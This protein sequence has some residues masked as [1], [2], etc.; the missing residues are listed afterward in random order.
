MV[1]DVEDPFSK[2]GFDAD[3][4]VSQ[5]LRQCGAEG[6]GAE[7]ERL[8]QVSKRA[9]EEVERIVTKHR[10]ALLDRVRSV[11]VAEREAQ[12]LRRDV[13]SLQR[14][15]QRARAE[16]RAPYE[17]VQTHTAQVKHIGESLEILR[18]VLKRKKINERLRSQLKSTTKKEGEEETVV[19]LPK[20]AR[21]YRELQQAAEEYDLSGIRVVE[22]DESWL[23]EAGSIIKARADA[24]LQQGMEGL[25]LTDVGTALLV[26]SNLGELQEAIEAQMSRYNR[27]VSQ[28]AG[29]WLEPTVNISKGV[30]PGG[31]KRVGGPTPGGTQ[32]WQETFWNQMQEFANTV[33]ECIHAVWF[34]Y[35]VMCRRRDPVTRSLLIEYIP[36][37]NV[38]E[39]VL[40]Q[41][42][43]EKMCA[44]VNGRIEKGM[45]SSNIRDILLANYPKELQILRSSLDKLQ[46]STR[47]KGVA[48]ALQARRIDQILLDMTKTIQTAYITRVL[49]RLNE[50]VR[51]Q[52]PPNLRA[53][54]PIG[55]PDQFV[56]RIIHE[57]QVA[58]TNTVL[59]DMV[60]SAA[61][62]T[63]HLLLERAEM[64]IDTSDELVLIEDA[65]NHAQ[66]RNIDICNFLQGV[67]VEVGR[68]VEALPV[69]PADRLQ[70]PLRGIKGIAENSVARMFDAV[71]Q[72][73][74]RCVPKMHA[75]FSSTTSAEDGRSRY[76]EELLLLLQKVQQ[77][78]LFRFVPQ[79]SPGKETVASAHTARIAD[80]VIMLFVRHATL[81][82]PLS[83]ASKLTLAQDV[84][85]LELGVGSQL[86]PVE[87][88]STYPALRALKPLL[89]TDTAELGNSNVLN[90]MPR[91]HLLHHLFSRA[92]AELQSPYARIGVPASHYSTWLDEHTDEEAISAVRECL[93]AYASQKDG[94]V[95]DPVYLVLQKLS[96]TDAI[97][98]RP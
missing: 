59:L 77:T 3:A 8:A 90:D 91:I 98:S 40:C 85:E 60:C 80:R 63:L 61:A 20:A 54:Q 24:L 93:E 16:L 47:N 82:R 73:L 69:G 17:A 48:T 51:A 22:E 68:F 92:P 14:S 11:E 27:K 56:G 76:M 36:G 25:S 78:L 29:S 74:E 52:F 83:E 19:D 84:A 65:P 67:E 4:Y 57:V 9:E 26:Y 89:F 31:V 2:E 13:M 49:G 34:L 30:G 12:E 50:A 37:S 15:A 72:A 43:I 45:R 38:S 70:S 42:L 66:E 41:M 55:S 33:Q 53:G 62:K 58:S 94:M 79:P 28:A 7:K 97:G 71:L 10:D 95:F 1:Q 23:K 86:W 39:C 75:E 96:G 35:M 87:E 81:V 46:K 18:W 64:S 5:I 6:M 32:E 21:L 44:S 88:L